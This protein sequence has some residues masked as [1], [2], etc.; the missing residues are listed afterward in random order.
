LRSGA[1][2]LLGS[3]GASYA[4]F[5]NACA[6]LRGDR[7]GVRMDSSNGAPAAAFNNTAASTRSGATAANWTII[8]PPIECP[9]NTA[10]RTPRASSAR[11]ARST[12]WLSSPELRGRLGVTPWPAA[13]S[14]TTK[15]P[16]PANR[17]NSRT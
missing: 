11:S 16:I 9:M 13:S 1:G 15:K 7:T 3:P 10:S 4:A 2:S 17:L 5:I 6:A 14:A 8:R 12:R